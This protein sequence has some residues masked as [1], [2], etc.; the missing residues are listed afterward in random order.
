MTREWLDS[1]LNKRKL[2]KP[3]KRLLCDYGCD[4]KEYRQLVG[5]LERTGEPH[6]LR[7]TY[8]YG[9]RLEDQELGAEDEQLTMRLMWSYT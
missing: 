8:R 1:F 5:V 6:E 9:V 3:D 2:V 4:D 7:Q